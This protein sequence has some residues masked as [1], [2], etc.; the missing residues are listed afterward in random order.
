M[1]ITRIVLNTGKGEVFIMVKIDGGTK[2][3]AVVQKRETITQV[4]NATTTAIVKRSTE[5]VFSNSRRNDVR[6]DLTKLR[7][8][9]ALAQ[10]AQTIRAQ[11]TPAGQVD[12]EKVEFVFDRI[13]DSEGL[14]YSISDENTYL[15]AA[16]KEALLAKAVRSDRAE[17]LFS[18]RFPSDVP[19]R[20][21]DDQKQIAKGLN[22][23]YANGT[24]TD[25]DLNGLA[26]TLGS[27]R[28]DTT[29]SQR[30]VTMLAQD[31]NNLH[32][33][34]IVEAYG[35]AAKSLGQEQAAALAFSSSEELIRG[36]LT[37]RDARQAAFDQVKTF[38]ESDLSFVPEARYGASPMMASAYV[39]GLTNAARL[40]SWGV[41]TEPEFDAML[42]K[43]GPR[44]V[45]EAIARSSHIEGDDAFN[46][47]LNEF[48]DA[49]RRL[50]Q[51]ADGDERHDWNV[52]AALAYTQ[53]EALI[54]G[55]LTTPDQRIN[56]FDLLNH[57]LAGY[58]DDARDAAKDGY[59][60][61]RAPA[62]AEGLAQLLESHPEEILTNKLGAD[63]KDYKGQADLI[64]LL[65]S[66]LFSPYTSAE[67]RN[68][69]QTAVQNYIGEEFNG[70]GNDSQVIGNR[71][72]SLLGVL[73]AASQNS[74]NA[75]EKPEEVAYIDQ[76]SKDFA[77]TVLKAG[78]GALLKSTG[79]VGSLVGDFV[80]D[81]VIKKVFDGKPPSAEQLG[82]AYI[83]LLEK[84][85][86]NISLGESLRDNYIKLLTDTITALNEVRDTA[87]GQDLA[88]ITDA[89]LEASQL[90]SGIRDGYGE[91]IDS[92]QLDNGQ[93]NRALDNWSKNYDEPDAI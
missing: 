84:N 81:E 63:G 10:T 60:L 65:E 33:G 53:S 64:N 66:T 75:A 2:A 30:F 93:I 77:K 13:A 80:L 40:H 57:E 32:S 58:R 9:G 51:K 17:Q 20:T 7:L 87:R 34:G 73:D 56:A 26:K 25:A 48:G 16:E 52:N 23:A 78:V 89:S 37:T 42:D 91:I 14:A 29:A 28:L 50:A 44:Y 83:D 27:D 90:L 5:Q 54:N 72:G 8:Q 1:T 79:P 82:N 35:K 70:A 62:M 41:S 92:Y 85:G 36:N 49:S 31:P 24:I 74:I 21:Y 76:V 6:L 61:L 55:N 3:A 39:Q 11:T 67:T 71:L 4:Q 43:A 46:S 22:A 15:N 19:N 18:P 38:L 88:N 68:R 45:Q 47:T 86:Q 69:I 59:S 12:Q